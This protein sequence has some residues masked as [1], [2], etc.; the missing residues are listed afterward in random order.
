[1]PLTGSSAALPILIAFARSDADER[2]FW[3]RTLEE[4][5][6]KPGDLERAVQLVAARGALAETLERARFYADEAVAALAAFPDGP[7][8]HALVE[9]AAFTTAR[10]F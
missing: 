9:T 1:M 5:D 2:A 3:R 6:Q 8:R 10:G 7:M 4:G